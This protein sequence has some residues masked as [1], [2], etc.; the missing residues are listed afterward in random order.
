MEH[1][2]EGSY[3][4]MFVGDITKRV[5]ELEGRFDLIICFQV[6]EHVKPLDDAIENLRCYLRPGGAA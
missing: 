5:A 6:L 2:P 1:A 4:E 3:D